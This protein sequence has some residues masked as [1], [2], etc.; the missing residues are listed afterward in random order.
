[1]SAERLTRR[2]RD[3][4]DAEL[5]FVLGR[6]PES[7]RELFDEVPLVVEDFPSP[8]VMQSMGVDD[9]YELCGLHVGQDL[10]R[11]EELAWG[12]P[13][14]EEVFIY[15]G[16]IIAT[17]ENELPDELLEDDRAFQRELRRQI[18]ITILHEYGHHYGMTEDELRELG[19][20]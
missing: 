10:S 1:M 18:R 2:E 20:D 11:R 4:F 7:V 17:A 3:Y 19:Y 15:R 6:L 13:D 12:P 5:E 14:P 9:P 16:G 8:A